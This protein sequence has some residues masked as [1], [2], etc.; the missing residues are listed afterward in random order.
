MAGNALGIETV[1]AGDLSVLS[2]NTDES[3][4]DIFTEP[5]EETTTTMTSGEV[6]SSKPINTNESYE[7]INTNV[8][9][10]VIQSGDSLWKIAEQFYGNGSKYQ[11]LFEE[12]R[13]VIKNPDLIFEGQKIRIPVG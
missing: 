3:I 1:Q 12:N 9:Y 10:Y 13:E 5:S 4:D 7:P 6:I 2:P 11:Q 8:S